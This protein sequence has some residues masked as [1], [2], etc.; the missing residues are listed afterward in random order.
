[1]SSLAIVGGTGLTEFSDISIQESHSIET[2]YGETSAPLLR[3]NLQ[4]KEVVFLARHGVDHT[5]PPHKINYRA[6]IWALKSIGVTDIIG[7]AA[8]GGI[9]NDIPPQKVIIPDQIIDYTYGRKNTFFE[10]DLPEVAHIDLTYPYH[11]GVEA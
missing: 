3:G 1:M 8:V 11:S 6:N 5:I 7:V 4:N 2:P 10:D 9:H